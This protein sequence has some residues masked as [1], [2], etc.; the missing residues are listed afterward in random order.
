MQATATQARTKRATNGANGHRP[1]IAKPKY[2]PAAKKWRTMERSAVPRDLAK[3]LKSTAGKIRKRC[4]DANLPRSQWK[5]RRKVLAA[6]VAAG[7]IKGARDLYDREFGSFGADAVSSAEPRP[8]A[9]AMDTAVLAAS[10]PPAESPQ[11]AAPPPPPPPPPQSDYAAWSLPTLCKELGVND[12]TGYNWLKRIG[13]TAKESNRREVL[14][15]ALSNRD[16]K[17]VKRAR[18]L[19]A[20]ESGEDTTAF[21]EH[22][23]SSQY[24]R[25]PPSPDVIDRRL[26]IMELKRGSDWLDARMREARMHVGDLDDAHIALLTAYRMLTKR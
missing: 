25:A 10:A 9:V 23:Q 26:V 13:K 14:G 8:S 21:Q 17:I 2:K 1:V 11:P 24:M 16:P 6:V 12:A 22:D 3:A 4:K 20:L 18:K 5:D 19:L 7:D 15:L